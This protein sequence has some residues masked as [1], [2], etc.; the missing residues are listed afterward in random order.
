MLRA[1]GRDRRDLGRPE[2]ARFHRFAA[3]CRRVRAVWR[4]RLFDSAGRPRQ[5]ER[6]EDALAHRQR[7]VADQRTRLESARTARVACRAV[8]RARHAAG[9][10]D[11][12]A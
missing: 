1:L 2:R 3:A 11:C 10:L 6:R 7:S 9:P 4:G 12:R 8:P 5:F